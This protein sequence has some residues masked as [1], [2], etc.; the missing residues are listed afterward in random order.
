MTDAELLARGLDQLGLAAEQRQ[1]DALLDYI[2]LIVKWNRLHNLTAVR[3]PREMIVRHLFDSLA[4]APYIEGVR[5]ADVGS[6]AGL[7]GI[8]LAIMQPE[9]AFVLID[10]AQKRT[11]FMTQ[12]VLELKLANVEVVHARV[13][14]YRPSLRFDTVVSRAFASLHDMLIGC[15]HLLAPGGV[16]LAMKGVYPQAEIGEI[17]PGFMLKDVVR[18][19]VPELHGDRHLVRMTPTSENVEA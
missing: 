17:P 15:A 2:A 18:L 5:V 7:P 16:F 19:H 13:E 6:G 9:R 3:E 8:P 4:V 14:D 10:S 12:A 11:R 1:R